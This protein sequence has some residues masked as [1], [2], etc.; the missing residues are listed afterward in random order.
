MII[1]TMPCYKSSKLMMTAACYKNGDD[2]DKFNNNEDKV[3]L[4]LRRWGLV[5][6]ILDHVL[7]HVLDHMII[8]LMT[9]ALHY[10]NFSHRYGLV[11]L[12]AT[13]AKS[14]GQDWH[15]YHLGEIQSLPLSK[16]RKI[17]SFCRYYLKH[18]LEGFLAPVRK[19]NGLNNSSRAFT[20]SF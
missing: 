7:D 4:L 14:R 12:A 8:S 11:L 13:S 6:H 9:M 10:S 17:K 18:Y 15:Y 16:S 19:D 1:M 20:N 5:G 3:C 2:N